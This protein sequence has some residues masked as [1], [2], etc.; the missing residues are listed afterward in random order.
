MKAGGALPDDEQE[1]LL[2]SGVS[3]LLVDSRLQQE[4]SLRWF[5]FTVNYS[6]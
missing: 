6:T 4:L 3:S 2:A 1:E 5:G